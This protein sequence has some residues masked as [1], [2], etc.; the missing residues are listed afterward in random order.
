[1]ADD[2]DKTEEPTGK[3]ISDAMGQGNVPKSAE[4]IGATNL[5]WYGVF[6]I[7]FFLFFC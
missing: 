6:I 2:E 3:R 1:M 4:V 5:F 7:S